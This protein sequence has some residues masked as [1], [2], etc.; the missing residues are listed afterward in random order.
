[1]RRVPHLRSRVTRLY[2]QPLCNHP[3]PLASD[4]PGKT[5]LF[6]LNV[7]TKQKRRKKRNEKKKRD[8]EES[9]GED[10]E[11]P[12]GAIPMMIAGLFLRNLL[13][14]MEARVRERE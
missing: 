5:E 12:P 1:M 7:Q 3:C 11:T 6:S 9:E 13:F 8:R 10:D 2:R 4:A 14:G